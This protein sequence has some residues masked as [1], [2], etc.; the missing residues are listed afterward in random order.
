MIDEIEKLIYTNGAWI[1][2]QQL[3]GR[4]QRRSTASISG[5]AISWLGETP[6]GRLEYGLLAGFGDH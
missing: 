6:Y 1:L 5:D 4:E 2:D 3:R